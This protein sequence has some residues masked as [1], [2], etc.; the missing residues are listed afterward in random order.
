MTIEEARRRVAEIAAIGWDDP[1]MA[2]SAEDALRHEA[3]KAIADG[4]AHQPA[5]LAAEVLR[6]DALDFPRWCA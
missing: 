2:H 5:A 4:V 3:L 6:S 1:E